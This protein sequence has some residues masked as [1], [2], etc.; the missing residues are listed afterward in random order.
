MATA[1]THYHRSV[2]KQVKPMK[3]VYKSKTLIF[4]ILAVVVLIANQFGFSDFQL[5]PETTATIVAVINF[6]L[7]FLTKEPLQVGA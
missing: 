4:N 5:D 7:R 2:V 6:V 1:V 3:P